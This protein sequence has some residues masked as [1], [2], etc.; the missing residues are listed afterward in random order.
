M[1]KF[2]L[3][4]FLLGVSSF[5]PAQNLKVFPDFAGVYNYEVFNCKNPNGVIETIII[6]CVVGKENQYIYKSSSKPNREIYLRV[7]SNQDNETIVVAFPEDNKHYTLE[8]CIACPYITCNNPD[9]SVQTFEL[10]YNLWGNRG[11]FRSTDRTSNVTEYLRIEGSGSKLKVKYSSSKNPKWIDLKVSNVK[12]GDMD[13]IVFFDVQFPN[14]NK[15][16]RITRREGIGYGYNC[17][18]PNGANQSF[19]WI[20]K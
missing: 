3:I 7:L 14:D 10:D 15:K 20:N 18:L 9:G 12:M 6:A 13:N 4:Q 11:T 19:I 17:Q 2:F 8:T 1:K 5:L 16:Y